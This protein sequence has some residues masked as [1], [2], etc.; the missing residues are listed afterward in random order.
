MTD[1]GG[2]LRIT[3]FRWYLSARL[4]AVVGNAVAPIAVSFAVLDLTGSAADLGLV[5]AARSVP[6]VVFLLFGGV[7]ADRLPRH[8][9]MVA[10][11]VVSFASQ[12]VAAALLLGGHAYV[13]QILVAEAVNGAASAFI[14]PAMAG[15]VPQ[16]VPRGLLQQASALGG[17]VRNGGM[18]LGAAFGGIL[19]A[20]LGSGWG[21]AVDAASFGAAA[22]LLLR[23]RPPA[24][25]A[26]APGG[27]VLRELRDGWREFRSRT[28][29][30]VVV[31]GFG[32]L[33][34]IEA[35]G[36]NTL[37]P[38][39]ADDTVG[40]GAWG[41]VLAAQSIGLVLATLAMLRLRFARPLRAG[42]IGIAAL[43]PQLAVLALYPTTWVLLPVSL[44][45]G[46]GIGMFDVA[47]ETALG[48]HVPLDRLSR[49]SAYDGLGSLLALP[50][51][52]VVAGH[53]GATYPPR[54][55][56]LA[57]SV[58]LALV[59]AAVLASRDVRTLP[60]TSG[61]KLAG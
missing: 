59:L 54:L 27:T 11:S 4:V 26:P 45:A 23:V 55:L 33:N 48:T 30:W 38:V 5:L 15:V 29:L 44:L 14:M 31:L 41:L 61:G 22:L 42:L 10:G 37:G 39:I 16:L 3:S 46:F 28:W 6:L 50:L 18:V 19:V 9:V 36:W 56:V 49:V 24:D 7:L 43:V 12:A 17:F 13:W 60:A 57:G 21:V 1:A 47:W 53:L 2:P 52:Q 8:L 35:G 40:R 34:A 20:A 25:D 51:G 58:L 32:V